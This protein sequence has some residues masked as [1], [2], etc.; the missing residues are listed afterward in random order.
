M[1]YVIGIVI[2]VIL[3]IM[4]YVKIWIATNDIRKIRNHFMDEIATDNVPLFDE[5]TINET[6]NPLLVPIL[7]F[8][9]LAV[10]IVIGLSLN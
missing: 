10:I 5:A 1:L 9:F 3:S 4:L 7:F 2:S 8:V 6:K